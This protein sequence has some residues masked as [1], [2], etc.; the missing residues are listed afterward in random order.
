MIFAIR[1]TYH[2]MIRAMPS[3]RVFGRDKTLMVKLKL[4]GNIS[5]KG[6]LI[7]QILERILI[8]TEK[9]KCIKFNKNIV[10]YGKNLYSGPYTIE[11]V[12]ITIA[13]FISE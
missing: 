12:K 11:Q 9:I 3:Q 5:K 1:V 2:V 6:K 4:T 7:D 13:Q 8:P 10:Q